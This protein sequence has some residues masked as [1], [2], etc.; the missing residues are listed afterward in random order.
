VIGGGIT[1]C[2]IARDAALRGLTVALVEKND[3]ANGTS[4]RSS[5]LIHGG[6]RYLEHGHVHLVFESSAERHRLLR[7]AP[8]LVRP[9]AF[10]WPVYA[11]ARI[12]R[13]KLGAGLFLYDVLA[14][15]RNVE[16]HQRL[17]RSAV[18]AREPRLRAEGL[19]GGARY[20]DAATNDARLTLA[21]AIGAAE[22]GAIVANH[23]AAATLLKRDGKVVGATVRDEIQQ[24]L[25]DVRAKVVV[26]ATGPW[27]DDVRSMDAKA[28]AGTSATR[29]SKGTHIA[30]PRD[31]VG[32]NDALTLL[33]PTDQRVFFVLPAGRHAI[34]GTTDTY[35]ASP[36]D[37]VRATNEDVRYL[38]ASANTFFSQAALRENDVVSAWAGIRPLLPAP[39]ETPGAVTREHAVTTSD[40]GL[41]TISGGKLTT[42]RVMAHDVLA[43]ILP[44]LPVAH[45]TDR[46]LSSPLPG[47]DFDSLEELMAKIDDA[48]GD[49]ALARHLATSYGTRWRD[50][51][52][53]IQAS[54]GADRIV[55]DLPYT[56]GEL[57]YCVANEF[58]MTLADLFIRRTHL[59][60]ETSDHG[61]ES[62]PRAASAIAPL[63]GWDAVA[64]RRA[65]ADYEREA[66]NIFRVDHE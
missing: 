6:V 48:T 43:A 45:S 20:F 41:V 50:V 29:G 52:S 51:F 60:F 49:P 34:I 21:N 25:I 8:H 23:L 64:E 22:A 53:S 1:G 30:V 59:A 17:S 14:L 38:L 12:P 2:A 44:R 46:T 27:S 62:A 26:N 63:L 42:Y 11:G 37:G 24:T 31:R 36:P 55:P 54:N 7:L 18:L 9:L 15:F 33:S 47:G 35:S 56:I 10:T 13:W 16:R 65:I 58:A 19:L 4:S 40:S 3:F 39:A 57:R 28:A 61:A 32:N 5:R 66:E